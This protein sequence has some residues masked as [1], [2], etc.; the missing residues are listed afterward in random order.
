MWDPAKKYGATIT[1]RVVGGLLC[2]TCGLIG[3]LIE[4][5]IWAALICGAIWQILNSL[6]EQPEPK[7]SGQLLLRRRSSH[8]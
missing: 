1:T 4:S 6:V 3:G 8:L 7:K 2:G 5:P